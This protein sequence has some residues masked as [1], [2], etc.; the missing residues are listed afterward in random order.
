MNNYRLLGSTLNTT[1]IASIF[2]IGCNSGDSAPTVSEETAKTSEAIIGGVNA[3][4]ASLN[5]V[6]ALVE[7]YRYSYTVCY[8][9][10]YAGGTGISKGTS[11]PQET[12]STINSRLGRLDRISPRWSERAL[13]SSSGS[14]G[15]T[16][17]GST[18]IPS[19][20]SAGGG[21]SV[22]ST[23]IPSGGSAGGTAM[24]GTS[25]IGTSSGGY[26]GGISTNCELIEGVEYWPFCSGTLIGPTTVM[27]AEHCLQNLDYMGDTEV[28][29]AVGPDAFNPTKLYTIVDYDWE[30]KVP[31]DSSSL[32]G[33]LGS[34]VGVA[35]LGEAVKNVTPMAIGTL[36]TKDVGKRFTALGY[37]VQNNYED[38]GTR[39]AGTVTYR[40]S[41]GNYA[42]YAFGGL[43]GFLETAPS[44]PYFEGLPEYYLIEM[45]SYLG[46]IPDYMG[47][48]GGKCGD[49]QP[50]YG[51]SGGPII[52]TKDGVKTVYG[53]VTN[54]LGSSRLI[55]DYGAVAAIFGP[56]TKSYL[57]ESLKWVDPCAGVSSKGYC[58]GDLAIRCT[59]RIE[60]SRRLTETDCS[61]LDQTCGVDETGAVAC[62]DAM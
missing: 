55:C 48:F 32:F 59:T 6:G 44:M 7:V 51:D 5:A 62:V 2:L 19:G 47:F 56:I 53:N 49:A 26:G 13:G 38:H 17:V 40:G 27:T 8:G 45:Y 10:G 43:E 22:G 50:C 30:A 9:G 42:D 60:G 33:D 36:S 23:V 15:G 31:A 39:K 24:G 28:A 11:V 52:G 61:M 16:S 1:L 35:H 3:K 58:D 4:S 41:G 20:G 34:D 12:E 46:L 21:T 14:G 37:G 54:G 57:E 29:F 25:S 18:V